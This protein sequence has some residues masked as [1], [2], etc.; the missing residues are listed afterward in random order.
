MGDE[1]GR[2]DRLSDGANVATPPFP[3]SELIPPVQI[4]PSRLRP[5][6]SAALGDAGERSAPSVAP[7]PP[8]LPG[9]GGLPPS[10]QPD[11]DSDEVTLGKRGS[12]LAMGDC[13]PESE[14]ENLWH[15]EKTAKKRLFTPSTGARGSPISDSSGGA[16]D[17]S[18]LCYSSDDQQSHASWNPQCLERMEPVGADIE[19]EEDWGQKTK[20]ADSVSMDKIREMEREQE[21]LSASLLQLTTH[22]AQVQFRLQQIVSADPAERETLLQELEEFAFRGIPDTRGFQLTP[23]VSVTGVGST[24]EAQSERRRNEQKELIEQLK[25]QLDDLEQYAYETGE[26]G[27]PTSVVFQKQRVII[28]QLRGRLDLNI[29]A[30]D[31]MDLEELRR[32]VDAAVGQ[33]VTPLKLKEQLVEQLATQIQ[34][35]ERFIEHLQAGESPT[36]CASSVPCSC[37]CGG[38]QAHK[39]SSPSGSRRW[40]TPLKASRLPSFLSRKTGQPSPPAPS[41]VHADEATSSADETRAAGQNGEQKDEVSSMPVDPDAKWASRPVDPP[42]VY[43]ELDLEGEGA[44][45]PELL[46]SAA[47]VS[48]SGVGLVLSSG[49]GSSLPWILS[50]VKEQTLRLMK[51][52]LTFLH[53]FAASQFG[54]GGNDLSAFSGHRDRPVFRRNTLK[55][56]VAGNHYGDMRARLEVAIDRVASLAEA[57]EREKE[58]RRAER[59]HRLAPPS[60]SSSRPSAG[61]SSSTTVIVTQP[62]PLISLNSKGPLVGLPLVSEEVECNNNLEDEDAMCEE[63]QEVENDEKL[64]HEL[65]KVVRKELAVALRDLM[66]HGLMPLSTSRSMVL[67]P[68]THCFSRRSQIAQSSKMMHAWDYILKFYESKNGAHYNATPQRCLSQSFSLEIVGG[69][70]VTNKQLLLGAIGS[71]ISTHAPLKRSPDAQLKA[72]I[73]EGLN[74]HKLVPWLKIL[75]RQQA[76]MDS[77]YMPWSYAVKTGFDD[78]FQSL[79]KLNKFQFKIPVDLAVRQLKNIKDA[80]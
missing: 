78:T 79:S 57:L 45:G 27:P 54:C 55:T 59:R 44:D 31:R 19:E 38:C 2:E 42:C 1:R 67:V 12:V 26:A 20:G 23:G 65:T 30:I 22:F 33:L 63:D 36:G 4:P 73:S 34:D 75:Y 80:F 17:D 21:Q 10:L 48:C 35:L 49:L 14:T 74:T 62:A 71:I 52:A 77:Y 9:E 61:P 25:A 24:D 41:G 6:D 50:Q 68:F 53:V 60:R 66:Q 51:R 72:L 11:E 29:N 16:G 58:V 37:Q 69:R 43:C 46:P 13:S 18:L 47:F 64:Q 5:S 39:E 56:T 70:P 3:S 7:A 15:T 76:L 32:H 8:S 40:S 28:E